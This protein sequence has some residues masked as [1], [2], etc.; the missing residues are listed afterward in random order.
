MLELL[1]RGLPDAVVV[2]F[3]NGSWLGIDGWQDKLR[4]LVSFPNVLL[5]LSIDRQHAMG[6]LSVARRTDPDVTYKDMEALMFQQ[7]ASFL[8]ESAAI[9][10][11]P[12]LDYD[13]AYKG[14]LETAERYLSELGAVPVYPIRFHKDPLNRP[15]SLGYLAIDIDTEGRPF[16][17][18]TLGHVLRWEPLG[19]LETLGE[20]LE[21]NRSYLQREGQQA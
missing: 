5:R 14:P 8:K 10:V 17:F 6:A 13:L 3:T 21:L 1:S 2:S 20:A 15:R 11:R 16:V 4:R 19:G 18:P 12:G 7:A 9:G